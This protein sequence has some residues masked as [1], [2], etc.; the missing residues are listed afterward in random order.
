MAENNN[1]NQ[2][3]TAGNTAL[4]PKLVLQRMQEHKRLFFITLPIVFVVSAVLIVAVPRT[5]TSAVTMAP[6]TTMMDGSMGS[7]S[8]LASSFGVNLDQMQ[9]TDAITPLLYP[10]LMGDNGFV[11][12]L[13]NVP[14]KSIDGKIDCTYYEYLLKK[15]KKTWWKRPFLWTYA[16][17]KKLI[18]PPVDF[19]P[20]GGKAKLD[21]YRLT[22]PQYDMAQK[23]RSHVTINI[24]KKT[25]VLKVTAKAQDPI[26]CKTI[27]DSTCAHL[28]QYISNYRTNKA[29]KDVVYYTKLVREAKRDYEIARLRYAGYA[30]ANTDAVY[31]SFRSKQDDLEND[32]QLK[33]NNYSS[34]NTQ[35][36]AAKAKVQENLPAFTVLQGAAV[37]QKAAAPKRMIFVA[38]MLILAFGCCLFYSLRKELCDMLKL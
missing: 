16:K 24:D 17:L 23:I 15:Q 4:T 34:L 21:P 22:K 13:F 30:D 19:G 9:T 33:F 27:A 2:N 8:S 12:S 29:R 3:T 28:Q 20:K 5:Y 7:L 31:E 18:S 11:C 35:L 37:A 1:Q 36:M 32:M 26:I 10:D 14:V 6:E 25:G 38:F